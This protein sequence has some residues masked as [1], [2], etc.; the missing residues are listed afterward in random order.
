MLY[1]V[2]GLAI[3]YTCSVS[4]VDTVSLGLAILLV[5]ATETDRGGHRSGGHGVGQ[6]Y[7]CNVCHSHFA[8]IL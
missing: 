7:M 6:P 8:E 4:F 1:S 5:H 3:P 2:I